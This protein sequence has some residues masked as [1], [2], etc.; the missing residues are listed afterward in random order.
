MSPLTGVLV[1]DQVAEVARSLILGVLEAPP[2]PLS[3]LRPAVG[4]LS[5]RPCGRKTGYLPA[6]VVTSWKL[7]IACMYDTFKALASVRH[8]VARY[9]VTLME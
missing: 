6:P 3:T 5:L 7:I 9:L 1:G 8:L 4:F 2:L